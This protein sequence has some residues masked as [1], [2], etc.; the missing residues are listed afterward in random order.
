MNKEQIHIQLIPGEWFRQ[1]LLTPVF[2]ISKEAARKYRSNGLWLEDKHW[3][4]DPANRI[5]YS[6]KA[7]NQWLG[8]EL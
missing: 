1:E 6:M 2:G 7:I 4:K 8:G 5:V 3:R